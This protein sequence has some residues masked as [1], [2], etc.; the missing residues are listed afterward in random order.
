MT[1]VSLI[2]AA[3]A[4]LLG[5][6]PA[7]TTVPA[8]P[9]AAATAATAAT[10]PPTDGGWPRDYAT[11]AG[12]DARALPAAGREL[13]R[14][15]AHRR[16]TRRSPTRPRARPSRRSARSRSKP[17]RASP[18][19]ERLVNFSDA[20][21]DRIELPDAADGSAHGRRRRD[22][23]RRAAR[24]ARH[25]ARSRARQHRQEPDHPEER[26]RREGR[27]AAD[28]LQHDAGGA[29][30]PRRRSDLEPDQGQRPASSRST[31]TGTCSSTRRRKT[32]YLRNDTAG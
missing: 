28:L 23:R 19:T 26:R 21:A 1:A 10:A 4:P 24:R 31:R 7:K 30:Q 25:R 27:P 9:A 6:Q 5:E 8:K 16:A 2:A 14:P 22:H 20:Q 15:E 18:S 17:T 13:G 11:P 3:G 12:A 32:F 29:G